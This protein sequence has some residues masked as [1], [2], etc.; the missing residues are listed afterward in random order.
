M[1]RPLHPPADPT[2]HS[3]SGPGL[4]S[5]QPPSFAEEL[6]PRR[7]ART[8][9]NLKFH[10]DGRETN[11]EEFH[12]ELD[13]LTQGLGIPPEEFGVAAA[14]CLTGGAMAHFR[15]AL[16]R[17]VDLAQK[18]RS[19]I[20]SWDDFQAVMKEGAFGYIPTLLQILQHLEVETRPHLVIRTHSSPQNFLQFI[21][22]RFSKLNFPI[23]EQIKI[24]FAWRALSQ[25]LQSVMATQTSGYEWSNFQQFTDALLRR[26]HTRDESPAASGPPPRGSPRWPA[27]VSCCRADSPPPFGLWG[28][29][30]FAADVFSP[31]PS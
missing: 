20:F 21:Q 28:C 30:F 1:D 3:M 26:Q 31:G 29:F 16:T 5:S 2:S 24:F 6:P 14:K 22:D 4:G 19:G 9:S 7:W 8:V 13:I 11:L 17:S 15:A 10:W 23:P 18:F 27:G 25:Q 12:I